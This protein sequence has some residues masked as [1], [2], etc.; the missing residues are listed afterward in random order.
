MWVSSN[1]SKAVAKWGTGGA[2]T[3]GGAVQTGGSDIVFD[4]EGR[5]GMTTSNTL[6]AIPAK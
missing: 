2:Y 4:E 3:K 1:R 5:Y 6:I